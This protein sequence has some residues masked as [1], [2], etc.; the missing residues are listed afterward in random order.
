MEKGWVI[1]KTYVNDFEAEIAKDML[2]NNSIEAI[3]INKRDSS[4]NSFGEIEL[5][6]KEADF[7]NALKLVE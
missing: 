3:L 2:N 1:I 6:V 7:D 4:F 5:F